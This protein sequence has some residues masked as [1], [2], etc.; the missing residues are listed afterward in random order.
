MNM[1][2]NERR[3]TLLRC[4]LKMKKRMSKIKNEVFGKKKRKKQKKKEI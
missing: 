4:L 3:Q 2:S 1:D